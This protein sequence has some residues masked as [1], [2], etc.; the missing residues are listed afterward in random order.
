MT[1][2]EC[3]REQRDLL[4]KRMNTAIKQRKYKRV[5]RIKRE[6]QNIMKLQS[7]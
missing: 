1:I 6:I 2:G 7:A 3:V 5:K 4:F